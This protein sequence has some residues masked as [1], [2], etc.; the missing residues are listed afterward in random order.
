MVEIILL[1]IKVALPNG[2]IHVHKGINKIYFLILFQDLFNLIKFFRT[3]L[4][5]ENSDLPPG[6]EVR[7]TTDGIRYF[8]DHNTHTTTFED[9]RAHVTPIQW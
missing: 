5:I 9:P 3:E 2:K 7:K 8:V 4:I 1:I 6:W